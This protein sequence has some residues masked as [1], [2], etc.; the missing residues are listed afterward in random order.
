MNFIALRQ[1]AARAGVPL[2]YRDCLQEWPILWRFSVPAVL[3]GA[4]AAPATWAASAW[5]VNQVDGYAQMGI[6]NAIYRIRI[7]PE[8]ILS[9]LLAPLLPV[10]SET[11]GSGDRLGYRKAAHSALA[12]SMGITAPF[13]LLQIAVPALTV[14]PYGSGYQGHAAVVQW[15][16][17]DL[18]L[19]GLFNPVMNQMI[20]SLNRMWLGFS[21]SV[22]FAVT[23]GT[24]S[25]FLVEDY[26][27][28]G[29]AAASILA[30]VIC[31]GPYL[32]YVRRSKAAFLSGLPMWRLAIALTGACALAYGASLWLNP[33]AAS[34]V[35]LVLIG[36]FLF[37]QVKVLFR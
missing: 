29:L 37:F 8:M 18:A 3:C 20:V 31:I 34:A 36:A 14:L 25:Y 7:V 28:A 30:H 4:L 11:F 2:A 6:F 23:F 13:A 17:F 32:Y 27:A 16:M 24:L 10:L 1:E 12:L 26:G 5:L 33:V 35:A 21:Y 15:S 22:A 19:M 9:M